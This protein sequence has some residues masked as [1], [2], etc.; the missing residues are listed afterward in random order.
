MTETPSVRLLMVV[1][2]VLCAGTLGACE[3]F[4]DVDAIPRPACVADQDCDD[5]VFCNGQERCDPEDADADAFGCVQ[6]SVDDL[7]D[8]GVE[9]TIDACD[10]EGRVVR[11]DPSNCDCV[12]DA[13]CDALLGGPCVAS[14]VCDPQSFTCAVTLAEEGAPCDDGVACTLNTTCDNAGAC[15]GA[16][17]NDEC[18]DGVFCNGVERCEPDDA[19]ADP[20]T[21]C[22]D[23]ALPVE[24]PEL[25]DGVECTVAACDEALDVLIHQ[26]TAECECFGPADCFNGTCQNFRCDLTTGFTCQA[27][28]DEPQRP[29]GAPC[30][31]D[32]RCTD[33]DACDDDGQCLGQPVNSLCD[34][35]DTQCAPGD[36]DASSVDGCL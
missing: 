2:G 11:H 6:S 29:A 20:L 24:D 26:P 35:P 19:N 33:G 21:G 10:E 9:C 17:V 31:D 7:V 25:D 8:D 14:A 1:G 22:I 18:D 28:L 5:A 32:I 15:L 12:S 36:P 4:S 3:A 34:D 27:N 16:R 23:G 30:D 13:Q